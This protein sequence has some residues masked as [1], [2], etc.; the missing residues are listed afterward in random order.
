MSVELTG[1]QKSKLRGMAMNL[2]PI[3]TVGKQ[4]VSES[5]AREI[6]FAL[7][8]IELVKIRVDAESREAKDAILREISEKT[9][10][11]L[12]GTVGK[13]A[14]FYRPSEKKLIRLD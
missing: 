13:T 2:K 14:S 7:S 8:R 12:C 4:G 11:V 9:A 1:K 6:S 10:G 3:V 5:V